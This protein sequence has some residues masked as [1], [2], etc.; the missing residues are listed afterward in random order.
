LEEKNVIWGG[1]EWR[2]LGGERCVD[3]YLDG[4]KNPG[5]NLSKE[6]RDLKENSPQV[7]ERTRDYLITNS[8]EN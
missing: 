1:W 4:A 5:R 2:T 8:K 3:F 7:S 6:K